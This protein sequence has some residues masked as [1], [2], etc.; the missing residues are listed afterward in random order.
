M[1]TDTLIV[2]RIELPASDAAA[3]TNDEASPPKQKWP[4]LIARALKDSMFEGKP[5]VDEVLRSGASPLAAPF[6]AIDVDG[7][8]VTI[9]YSRLDGS[10]YPP[11]GELVMRVASAAAKRGGTGRIL[12]C[13]PNDA[14]TGKIFNGVLVTLG[15]GKI[16]AKKAKEK[17]DSKDWETVGALIRA[18]TPPVRER[19]SVELD[20]AQAAVHA[21]VVAI[22]GQVDEAQLRKLGSTSVATLSGT[23]S[24][25]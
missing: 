11:I 3:W 24:R 21:E 18:T 5:S 23:T 7:R 14:Q 2:G 8:V 15:K 4:R 25:E 10:N 17:F 6:G 20:A 22:L 9:R 12:F 1:S 16:A 13:D 19:Q